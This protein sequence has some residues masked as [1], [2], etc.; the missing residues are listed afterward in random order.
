MTNERDLRLDSMA[1]HVFQDVPKLTAGAMTQEQS[2]EQHLA[3]QDA[4]VAGA[5]E[6]VQAH[7]LTDK[8]ETLSLLVTVGRV[9]AVNVFMQLFEL[10]LLPDDAAGLVGDVWSMAEYPSR[11]LDSWEWEQLFDWSGYRHDG[12]PASRPKAPLTLYR[13]APVEYRECMSWT[14]SRDVA[15]WFNTRNRDMYGLDS[16]VWVATVDPW[17][18]LAS[19][20]GRQEAEYVVSVDGLVDI[21]P[22]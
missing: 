18:L 6:W 17:Y 1:E 14:G 13:G 20:G 16:R 2:V 22:A 19:V 12:E 7:G 15:E 9:P 21:R 10:D 8:D 3:A 11:M 4:K 5:V